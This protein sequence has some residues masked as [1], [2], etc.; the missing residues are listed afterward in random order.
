MSFSIIIKANNTTANQ[1]MCE[2]HLGNIIMWIKKLINCKIKIHSFKCE[3]SNRNTIYY[4]CTTKVAMK[5]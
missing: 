3:K 2:Q 1:V 5:L 4:K